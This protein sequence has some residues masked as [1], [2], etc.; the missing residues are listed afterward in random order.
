MGNI[1][2][3]MWIAISNTINV[4]ADILIAKVCSMDNFGVALLNTVQKNCIQW[5]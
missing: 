3:D 2:S 5:I 4:K 1:F